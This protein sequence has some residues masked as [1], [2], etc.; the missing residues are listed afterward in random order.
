MDFYEEEERG[1]EERGQ[2]KEKKFTWIYRM[3]RIR[4][5]NREW[6]RMDA[7]KRNAKRRK[8]IKHPQIT[9]IF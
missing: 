8:K 9:Q 5:E 2:G 1:G 6:T 3:D 7:N 4:E